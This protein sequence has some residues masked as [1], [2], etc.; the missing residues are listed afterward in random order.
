MPKERKIYLKTAMTRK[1]LG[2]VTLSALLFTEAL[3]PVHAAT[4]D[5]VQ[6]KEDSTAFSSAENRAAGHTYEEGVIGFYKYL[7]DPISEMAIRMIQNGKSKMGTGSTATFDGSD[8]NDVTYLANV[9]KS[10][11]WVIKGND[12]RQLHGKPR[13]KISSY[14]MAAGQIQAAY[15]AD[16]MEHSM[17]FGPDNLAWGYAEDET[18]PY[19]GW[20]Y[21]EKEI[22]DKGGSGVTGHYEWLIE[23]DDPKY[24][25]FGYRK[26]GK[27][28]YGNCMSLFFIIHDY[29]N[30]PMNR[31]EELSLDDHEYYQKFMEYY[32]EVTDGYCFPGEDFGVITKGKFEKKNGKWCLLK[33]GRPYKEGI[34]QFEGQLYALDSKGY[35][36]HGFQKAPSGKTYYFVSSGEAKTGWLHLNNLWYAFNEQG[37]MYANHQT[38][39][40]GGKT[41]CF[42]EK[43][44]MITGR[45][46]KD[47]WSTKY[48]DNA[49]AMKTGWMKQNGNWYFFNDSGNLVTSDIVDGGYSDENG[50][51]HAWA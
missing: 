2:C 21:K 51:W 12:L 15:S 42:D 37:E 43:G 32:D 44:V 8:P 26:G 38:M 25:G 4:A 49:G 34:Y 40:D 23:Y 14:A 10:I 19:A 20:Y 39:N 1:L 28:G 3:W 24:L 18:G 31:V 22:Y 33:N 6:T 7:G 17:I 41:Y 5:T 46:V 16:I 35:L 29:E 45:F 48:Y 30:D 13:L 36:K 47:G 11:E 50:I 27:N 9:K